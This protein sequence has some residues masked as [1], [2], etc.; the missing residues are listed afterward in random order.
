[1]SVGFDECESR[2]RPKS[3][4]RASMAISES[5]PK[6][7]ASRTSRNRPSKTPTAGQLTTPSTPSCCRRLSRRF[8]RAGRVVR[9]HASND[10]ETAA[11]G[12]D[13]LAKQGLGLDVS[14]AVGQERR[15]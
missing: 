1:M 3:R 7:S 11:T 10:R 8:E 15:E 9:E 4:A 12:Q 2:E 14:V 5:V 13:V 6:P